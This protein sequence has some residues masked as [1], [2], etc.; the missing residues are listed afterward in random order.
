MNMIHFE[1]VEGKDKGEVT[2][3]ALSTCVWCKRTK[4]LLS[5]LNISYNYVFVDLVE[6]EEKEE[7]VEKVKEHNPRCSYPTLVINNETC[8]VG[9]KKD[10]IIESLGD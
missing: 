7:V 3:F 1:H 9:F 2:L 4:K 8:I 10:Q 6:G 5:D